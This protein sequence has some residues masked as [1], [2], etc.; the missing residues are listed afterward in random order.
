MG[1]CIYD[2]SILRSPRGSEVTCNRLNS[3][4]TGVRPTGPSFKRLTL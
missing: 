4:M 1:S 3:S 2:S